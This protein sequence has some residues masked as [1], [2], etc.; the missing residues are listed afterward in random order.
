MFLMMVIYQLLYF[1][2][3]LLHCPFKLEQF[4]CKKVTAGRLWNEV[5]LL[6]PGTFLDKRV[7]YIQRGCYHVIEKG[8]GQF[9]KHL[10]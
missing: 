6:F 10:H 1:G 5:F 3:K 9:E 4:A 7:Q 8:R 2:L